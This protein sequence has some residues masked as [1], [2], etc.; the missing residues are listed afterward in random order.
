MGTSDVERVEP[1]LG[2]GIA[3]CA[4]QRFSWLSRVQH[5]IPDLARRNSR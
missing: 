2:V 4:A 5:A 3:R 1:L